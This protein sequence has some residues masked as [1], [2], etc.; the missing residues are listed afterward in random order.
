[1]HQAQ[2]LAPRP[3]SGHDPAM[4]ASDKRSRGSFFGGAGA[5]LVSTVISQAFPDTPIWIWRVFLGLG[6]ALMGY[7]VISAIVHHARLRWAAARKRGE[8]EFI[9]LREAGQWLYDNGEQWLRDHLGDHRPF[10]SVTEHAAAFVATAADEGVGELRASREP[11]LAPEPARYRDIAPPPDA[12]GNR[13]KGWVDPIFRRAD[14]PKVLAHYKN[15]IEPEAPIKAEVAG[16]SVPRLPRPFLHARDG[17]RPALR[18]HLVF[19]GFVPSQT[20]REGEVVR[21]ESALHLIN[22]TQSVLPKCSVTVESVVRNKHTTPIDMR[23]PD[24]RSDFE[25]RAAPG[26]KVQ[27]PFLRRTLRTAPDEEFYL[28]V[29]DWFHLRDWS[30]YEVN[31]T[32]DSGAGDRYTARYRGEDARIRGLRGQSDRSSFVAPIA[33]RHWIMK[34]AVNPP[35]LILLRRLA[36]ESFTPMAASFSTSPL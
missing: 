25:F 9:P 2:Q 6:L 14:L 1:M 10:D 36:S 5:T 12:L 35:R 7:G 23:L 27:V 19:V 26:E 32:I 11:G 16:I 4:D 24:Y 17:E 33:L 30:T 21:V 13:R 28:P 34:A 3:E 22:K 31:V 18:P 29:G 20:K 8:A 15:P